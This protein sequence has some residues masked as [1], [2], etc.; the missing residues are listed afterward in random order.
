MFDFSWRAAIQGLLGDVLF[1][2]AMLH[3]AA[4]STASSPF[5]ILKQNDHAHSHQHASSLPRRAVAGQP[6]VSV[7]PLSVHVRVGLEVPRPEEE[8]SPSPCDSSGFKAVV[9][10]KS[11]RRNSKS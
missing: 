10:S 5:P 8:T 11:V 2:S 7:G 1:S 6:V 3:P 9:G 4:S